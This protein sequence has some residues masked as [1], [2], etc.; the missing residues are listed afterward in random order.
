MYNYEEEQI[1]R[2]ASKFL[3]RV[4]IND[5]IRHIEYVAK[6]AGTE[7]VGIGS[8]FDGIPF[9]PEGLEDCTGLPV[10]CEMLR[11]RGFTSREVDR[12][13][14]ENFLRILREVVG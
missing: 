1:L 12:I 7:S 13:A 10:L 5:A 4:T 6:I 8:D 9:W 2:S 3:P 11:K 14:G